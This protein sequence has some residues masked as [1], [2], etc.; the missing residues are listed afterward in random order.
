MEGLIIDIIKEQTSIHSRHL[1]CTRVENNVVHI[2]IK[3]CVKC[4]L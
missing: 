1:T 3:G 2:E 4:K